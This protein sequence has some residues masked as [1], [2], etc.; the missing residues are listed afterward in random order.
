[1]H[2]AGTVL[3]YRPDFYCPRLVFQCSRAVRIGDADQCYGIVGVG[4]SRQ[5]H[6]LNLLLQA[7]FSYHGVQISPPLSDRRPYYWAN[8][9]HPHPLS[10][11]N[12]YCPVSYPV[13]APTVPSTGGHRMPVP[14]FTI[15][16]VPKL[17]FQ[18]PLFR[19]PRCCHKW[20]TR[21]CHWTLS[22]FFVVLYLNYIWIVFFKSMVL[23]F[24]FRNILLKEFVV[25]IPLYPDSGLFLIL[26][27]CKI[28]VLHVNNRLY[29]GP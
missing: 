1:M 16:S 2:D 6:I 26:W 5:C 10:L 12:G 18:A 13:P 11:G 8:R 29:Y 15:E 19:W 20:M 14:F 27:S 25:Y 22:T 21:P 23:P 9:L 28:L 17:Y 3:H 4:G 7:I 24:V